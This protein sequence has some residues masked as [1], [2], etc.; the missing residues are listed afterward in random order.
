MLRLHDGC[1]LSNVTKLPQLYLK[2]VSY[3]SII[4]ERLLV[5]FCS[6]NNMISFIIGV[7]FIICATF[8]EETRCIPTGICTGRMTL[9]DGSSSSQYICQNDGSIIHATYMD[10]T[11]CSGNYTSRPLNNS[12]NPYEQ[13][14]VCSGCESYMYYKRY[15]DCDKDEEWSSG[16]VE[17]L[18]PI[19]C[20]EG[21]ELGYGTSNSCSDSYIHHITYDNASCANEWYS[22]KEEQ[23]C[24]FSDLNWLY[25][26]TEIYYCGV[27]EEFE[28]ESIGIVRNVPLFFVSVV[29]SLF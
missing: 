22:W 16:W 23:G 19:G 21:S 28:D 15:L 29:I 2:S 9:D 26:Y 3:T 25:Y 24:Y 18:S 14:V 7:L 11:D 10:V 17:I 5:H 13:F 6:F 12:I 20:F 4:T 27:S 1:F 8:G